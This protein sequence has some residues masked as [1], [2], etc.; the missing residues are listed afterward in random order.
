MVPDATVELEADVLAAAVDRAARY[1]DG[2]GRVSL[3]ST[4]GAVL[5]R[6]GGS[7]GESEEAVK[8]TVRGAPVVRHY[9]ARLLTDALRALAGHAVE[10]R[11]Q[12]GLRATEVTAAGTQAQLR[13]LVVPMRQE[14]EV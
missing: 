8:A 4:D 7:H 3:Q 14:T 13:Y 1:A 10:L 11:V 2:Y 9:Q 5:V 6:A 12:S